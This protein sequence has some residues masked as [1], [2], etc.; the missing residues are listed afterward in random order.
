MPHFHYSLW[1]H[2]PA[3]NEWGHVV[4]GYCAKRS[5]QQKRRQRLRSSVIRRHL[6]DEPLFKSRTRDSIRGFFSPSL[7]Q[8]V[9]LLVRPS[10]IIKS[11]SVKT[12]IS[13]ST[14]VCVC[15]KGC[16]EGYCTPSPTCLR[17]YGNPTLL[18]L[19]D[20]A[21]TI[22]SCKRKGKSLEGR[23]LVGR[24]LESQWRDVIWWS[25]LL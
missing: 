5:N 17:R 2:V 18:V 3:V 16:V 21:N 10:V 6:K 20:F 23:S 25:K 14:Y 11:K 12:G 1:G 24:S 19:S 13:A 8:C 9:H 15:I 22:V 7:H 4:L